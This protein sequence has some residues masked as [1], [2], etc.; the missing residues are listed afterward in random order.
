MDYRWMMALAL[1]LAPVST[2][3]QSV[4]SCGPAE[5]PSALMEG[6]KGHFRDGEFRAFLTD[7]GRYLAGEVANYDS[8]FGRM[9]E[10]FPDGFALCQTVL[11]RDEEPGFRQEVVLYEA[12]AIDG[13][14][15]LLLTSVIVNGREELLYFNFN[16]NATA[17]LEQLR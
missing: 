17:I 13:P 10:L 12:E 11:V 8:Y 14:I 16:S 6:L 5:R 4:L 2:G 9:D 1:V 3:A 15:S 7:S